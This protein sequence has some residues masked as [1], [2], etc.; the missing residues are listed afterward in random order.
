MQRSFSCCQLP[1]RV[2]ISIHK[3]PTSASRTVQHNLDKSETSFTLTRLPKAKQLSFSFQALVCQHPSLFCQQHR[4]RGHTRFGDGPA[5]KPAFVTKGC[6]W[7]LWNNKSSFISSSFP[8]FLVFLVWRW[9][10]QGGLTPCCTSLQMCS[11][12]PY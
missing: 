5:G 2:P 7:G 1:P 10:Q 6:G 4:H 9:Y 8:L 11:Y 12:I 3:I